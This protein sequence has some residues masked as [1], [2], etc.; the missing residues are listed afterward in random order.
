MQVLQRL[1]LFVD[2][3]LKAKLASHLQPIVERAGNE[4]VA[5]IN[6]HVGQLVRSYVAVAIARETAQ[7]RQGE[8]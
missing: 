4:L 1:D 5:A 8:S 3:G 2:A 6:E 7:L